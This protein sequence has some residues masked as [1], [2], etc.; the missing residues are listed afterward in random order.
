M[1]LMS[2]HCEALPPLPLPPCFVS[3]AP[4]RSS[5]CGQHSPRWRRKRK[6]DDTKVTLKRNPNYTEMCLQCPQAFPNSD[7]YRRMDAYRLYS[8]VEK[9]NMFTFA[10]VFPI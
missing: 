1:N 7:C 4:A 5:N 3:L 10:P 8:E 6:K 9:S 2:H